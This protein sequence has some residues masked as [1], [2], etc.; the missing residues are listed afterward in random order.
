MATAKGRILRRFGNRGDGGYIVAL[1]GEDQCPWDLYMSVGVGAEESFT[2]DFLTWQGWGYK[3]RGHCW[4][5]DGTIVAY[6]RCYVP[7][8]AHIWFVAKNIGAN[9]TDTTVNLHQLIGAYRNVFLKMDIEGAEYEWLYGV[10]A[11]GLMCLIRQFIVEFHDINS[12]IN[13]DRFS[14]VW[15]QIQETHRVAHIHGNNYGGMG[16]DAAN[17]RPNVIEVTFVRYADDGNDI[18]VMLESDIRFCPIDGLDYPN[19]PDVAD[20]FA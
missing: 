8:G 20:I 15:L 3:L 2:W 14:G 10:L 4:A 12:D 19:N 6:P 13:K 11:A 7:W 1:P 9:M 5:F 17:P 16:G 18:P